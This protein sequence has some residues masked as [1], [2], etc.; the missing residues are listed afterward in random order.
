MTLDVSYLEERIPEGFGLD[1]VEISGARKFLSSLSNAGACWGVVTS[2]TRALLDTWLHVLSLSRPE[3][4]VVAE[5]VQEGKPHPACYILGRE[6]LGLKDSSSIVVL[7]NPPS[8][9]RAG[10]RKLQG[11]CVDDDALSQ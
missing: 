2:G 9:V 10:S 8:G 6:C 11:N 7:E 1:S 5:D 4:L 3:M